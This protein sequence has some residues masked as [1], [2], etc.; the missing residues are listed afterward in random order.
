MTDRVYTIDSEFKGGVGGYDEHERTPTE[1]GNQGD[2]EDPYVK[3]LYIRLQALEADRE[4]MRQTMISIRTD[5]EQFVLLKEIAHHLRKE[6]SNQ[7][8]VTVKIFVGG[9]SFFTIF[10]SKFMDLASNPPSKNDYITIS[11]DYPLVWV[12]SDDD[13]QNGAYSGWQKANLVFE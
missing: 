6:M 8:K 4:S 12:F 13:P 10:K 3:K 7:K 9:F 1:F 5:K 11:E 2:F